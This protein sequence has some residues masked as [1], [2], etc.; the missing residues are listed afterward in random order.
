MFLEL[1][2]ECVSVTRG[3]V[4]PHRLGPHLNVPLRRR[5]PWRAAASLRTSR[6]GSTPTPFAFSA[7]PG[8]SS[9]SASLAAAGSGVGYPAETSPLPL[10]HPCGSPEREGEEAASCESQRSHFSPGSGWEK[11]RGGVWREQGRGRFKKTEKS[12]RDDVRADL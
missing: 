9:G 4:S 11:Y 1:N 2:S 12:C 10:P 5:S 7:S 6:S 3:P 8:P